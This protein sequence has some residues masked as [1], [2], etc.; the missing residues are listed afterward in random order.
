[1][2][3]KQVCERYSLDELER[4][5]QDEIRHVEQDPI[6]DQLTIGAIIGLTWALKKIRV[7]K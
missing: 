4:L 2:L 1:M 6:V 5:I 7:G 3:V